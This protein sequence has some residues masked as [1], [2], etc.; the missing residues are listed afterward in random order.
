MVKN[1]RKYGETVAI[2]MAVVFSSMKRTGKDDNNNLPGPQPPKKVLSE[3]PGIF[4]CL[5]KSKNVK[6]IFLVNV[7]R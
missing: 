1:R 5:G 2:N 6:D 4:P 7:R 3:I